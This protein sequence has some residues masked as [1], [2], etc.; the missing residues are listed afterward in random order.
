MTIATAGFEMKQ[1]SLVTNEI[2]W[3]CKLHRLGSDG[4]TSLTSNTLISSRPGCWLIPDPSMT[5]GGLRRA[6][7]GE[8]SRVSLMDVII[9][10][11]KWW[12]RYPAFQF[13]TTSCNLILKQIHQNPLYFW[14]VY[15][16][17]IKIHQRSIKITRIP[18]ESL[19]F[20]IFKPVALHWR[21]WV[22][23]ALALRPERW[24]TSPGGLGTWEPHPELVGRVGKI[25]MSSLVKYLFWT[26][27][28]WSWC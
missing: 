15:I 26:I 6:V 16:F 2:W 13:A 12:M 20:S 21:I 23:K 19:I 7:S 18:Y 1:K 4:K 22:E 14:I 24:K 25:T 3:R 9:F 8:W 27:L 28:H 17:T 10:R 5:Q 11:E